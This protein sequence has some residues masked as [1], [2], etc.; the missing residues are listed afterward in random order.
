MLEDLRPTPGQH[1]QRRT[2]FARWRGEQVVVKWGLD[3]DLPEKI[4]YV[5]GQIAELRSRGIPAAPV[6]AHGTMP[7][8]GYAWL[9]PRLPGRPARPTPGLLDEVLAL[10]DRMR[11]APAGPHRSDYNAWLTQVVRDDAAGYWAN[12]A[13][14]GADARALC[15]RVRDSVDMSRTPAAA[16][17]YVHIDLN[18]GNILT[19]G[20]T[21]VGL[22]DLEN[23]G[24][25]SG[26]TDVACLAAD[27]HRHGAPG[28]AE[29]V[30]YGRSRH[31][32]EAWRWAVAH[33]M[34]SRLGWR[35]EHFQALD[36][37][38]E[39]APA[40]AWFDAVYAD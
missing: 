23:L 26:A 19:D 13:A 37:A 8:G 22:I 17:D 36:P 35:S 9:Q 4:P 33:E 39:V 1:G 20:D 16:L 38:A 3:P 14:L 40:A 7:G 5:A 11:A 31:G 29:I 18:L 24:I 15:A 32:E 21:I 34:A 2:Y 28:L 6:L 27:W 10:L 25:G 12:A 30:H